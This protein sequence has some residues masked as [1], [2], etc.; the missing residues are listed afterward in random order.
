VR[1]F[2]FGIDR[3]RQRFDGRQ[4]HAIQ[5]VD[6]PFRVLQPSERRPHRQ[7]RNEEQR[8]DQRDDTE[9]HLT[10]RDDQ[11]QCDRCASGVGRRQRH[12]VFAP[13]PERTL[14]GL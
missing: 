5:L 6:V 2:I 1:D 8:Q 13:H 9:V 11:Q 12:E 4:I 10:E 14:A 7:V 3:S